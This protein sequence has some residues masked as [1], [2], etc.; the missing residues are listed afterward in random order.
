M[1]CRL[2][3]RQYNVVMKFVAVV[4]DD[5]DADN[6]DDENRLVARFN[7]TNWVGF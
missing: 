2:L 1:K 3:G 4:N 7:V 5:D 6:D